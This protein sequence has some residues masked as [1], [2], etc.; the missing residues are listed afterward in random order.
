MIRICP[1]FPFK[2]GVRICRDLD[3][4][5]KLFFSVR[6]RVIDESGDRK[7]LS[8]LYQYPLLR[9]KTK[10]IFSGAHVLIPS[11]APHETW[12]KLKG[13]KR[14][15]SS[16]YG[17]GIK[18]IQYRWSGKLIPEM[19]FGQIEKGGQKYTWFQFERSPQGSL[20]HLI[21][22]IRY[23]IYR[24]NIGPY[25]SSVHTDKNPIIIK[26][27]ASSGGGGVGTGA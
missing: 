16:H 8:H 15:T 20:G 2:W 17:R 27:N 23:R 6:G 18:D 7:V 9:K 14:R 21:D 5:V 13:C 11:T 19:L 10:E 24:K 3:R 1:L 22:L 12:Q 26:L 4:L 25:G